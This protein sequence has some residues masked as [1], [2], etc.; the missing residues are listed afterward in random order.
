VCATAVSFPHW[1]VNRSSA[2]D[3]TR[4]T[5]GEQQELPDG[6]I[7]A[8]CGKRRRDRGLGFE[9]GT[10]RAGVDDGWLPEG[11]AIDRQARGHTPKSESCACRVPEEAG[12]LAHRGDDRREVVDLAV[13]QVWLGVATVAPPATV[14]ADDGEVLREQGRQFAGRSGSEVGER[15]IDE[16]DRR[17]TPGPL[18]RYPRTVDRADVAHSRLHSVGDARSAQLASFQPGP[19]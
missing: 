13:G 11:G 3:R 16:D 14:V 18:K 8:A 6:V 17:P 9:A 5:R 15:P 19:S 1:G 7:S 4:G 12:R 10:P 2:H